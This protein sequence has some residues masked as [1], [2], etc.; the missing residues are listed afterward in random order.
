MAASFYGARVATSKGPIKA[1]WKM[2]SCISM[3]LFNRR[4]AGVEDQLDHYADAGRSGDGNE[5]GN[6]GGSS[7]KMTA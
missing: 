1:Q 3:N 5:G 4:C 7:P 2:A 6:N